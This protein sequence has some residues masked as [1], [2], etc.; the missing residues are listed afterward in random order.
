MSPRNADTP[1][2]RA[3]ILGGTAEARALAQATVAAGLG[4][5]TPPAGR[6]APPRGLPRHVRTGGFGGAQGM[7]T[8]LIEGDYH[9][10]ID[11]T[12]P[13][14]AAISANAAEAAATTGLPFLRLSRPAWPERPGWLV[15]AGLAEAAAS[16]PPGASVLLAI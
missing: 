14:A 13:F 15:V 6:P 10:L 5:P 11:A 1:R 9:A 7:I 2:F 8:A 16:L 12:H 4:V 3:L